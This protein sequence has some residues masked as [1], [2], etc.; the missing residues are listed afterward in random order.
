MLLDIWKAVTDVPAMAQALFLWAITWALPWLWNSSRSIRQD[1]VADVKTA[2]SIEQA[3]YALCWYNASER[4]VGLLNQSEARFL[5][6]QCALRNVA[7]GLL[8]T[9]IAMA[10]E[11][12]SFWRLFFLFNGVAFFGRAARWTSIPSARTRQAA[13]ERFRRLESELR[14]R[15]GSS[16]EQEQASNA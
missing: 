2:L 7:F 13:E 8:F 11:G 16:T 1:A 9:S 5:I 10:F 15:P 3:K 6:L 12:G 14:L 4:S